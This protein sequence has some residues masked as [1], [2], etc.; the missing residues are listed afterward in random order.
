M[1]LLAVLNM[2]YLSDLILQPLPHLQVTRM[3]LTSSNKKKKKK[4]YVRKMKWFVEATFSIC[5]PTIYSTFSH[6]SSL[7]EIWKALEHKYTIGK[8]GMDKF[9]IFK[10]FEFTM[11]YGSSPWIT[12]CKTPRTDNSSSGIVP[13]VAIIAKLPT[14]WNDY[15][16]KVL[17]KSEDFSLEDIKKTF[18]YWRGNPNSG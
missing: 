2:S 12:S 10:Y 5:F 8:I 17:Q 16:K 7:Q 11:I 1:F 18:A 13:R 3:P 9:L 4:E 15:Q 14:S 6:L